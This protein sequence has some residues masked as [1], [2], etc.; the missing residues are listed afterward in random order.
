M[1]EP[2]DRLQQGTRLQ[3]PIY[4]PRGVLLL[5]AG[6]VL[7]TH[8]IELLERREISLKLNALLTVVGGPG[9]GKEI[10]LEG[11]IVKIGRN[12]KCHLRPN[13]RLVSSVHCVIHFMRVSLYLEDMDSTNGTFVN[14]T[15]IRSATPLRDHDVIKFGDMSVR[16]RIF[17]ALVGENHETEKIAG[18]I[19][20]GDGDVEEPPA[21]D[22]MLAADPE[23]RKMARTL[24]RAWKK[25]NPDQE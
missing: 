8:I 10:P 7:T 4:D 1:P 19:L 23:A 3:Y 17:A 12:A 14:G 21:G 25:L 5:N 24:E 15:R 20:G 9:Y 2:L 6:V 22:T 18:L 13:S 16:L 11:P